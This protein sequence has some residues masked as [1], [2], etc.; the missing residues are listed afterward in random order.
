MKLAL[1][2]CGAL[3]ACRPAFDLADRED[4]FAEPGDR[5]VM[6]AA[7]IEWPHHDRAVIGAALDRARDQR[8]VV[9][10]F[11]HDPGVTVPVDKIAMV[12]DDADARGLGYVTYRE[13]AGGV[14]REAAL[15]LS[16]DDY[17][18]EDWHAMRDL[19]RRH[20]A[21][22]TFFVSDYDTFTA[23]QRRL[24]D[25]LAADGHDVEYH[26]T[27]HQDARAYSQAHGI[28]AWL[29]DDIDPALAAMRA[30]GWDP[31]V[32]A[33]PSGHRTPATD[34]ALLDREGFA[35]LR[36]VMRECPPSPRVATEAAAQDDQQ[37][38]DD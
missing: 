26:S 11:A 30:D 32:F 13:L 16:F 24:L 6:C 15:A 33:Y 8:E 23:D 17:S 37:S 2:A 10:L 38:A 7:S 5:D 21:R 22:V 28:D 19:F 4:I 25:D 36:G 9:E 20:G 18:I 35:L 3:A 27:R 12:L 14:P 1:L 29:A 31:T 34:R